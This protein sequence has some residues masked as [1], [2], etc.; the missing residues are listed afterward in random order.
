MV[1]RVAKARRPRCRRRPRIG[2]FFEVGSLWPYDTEALPRRGLHDRPALDLRHASGS[3]RFQS[4][5]F[6]FDVVG[7]DVDV[8][9]ARM[10]NGLHQYLDLIGWACQFSIVG[11]VRINDGFGAA[12]Q[13]GRPEARGFVEISSSGNR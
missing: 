11:I 5:H 8:Y 6:G 4:A 7:L 9:S 3:E 2:S 13:R 12:T 10:S 1:S